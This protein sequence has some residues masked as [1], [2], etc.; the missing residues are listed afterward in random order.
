MILPAFSVRDAA[1]GAFLPPFFC[2]SKG[3]AIRSFAEA[4]A[5]PEHQFSKHA[6]DY[7]LFYVG[8]FDDHSGVLDIPSGPERIIG[9]L[10]VLPPV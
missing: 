3:E 4:V 2:R 10:E 1:V 6:G 8:S 9:A 5:N 7:A